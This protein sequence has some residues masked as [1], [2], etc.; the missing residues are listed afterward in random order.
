[1]V[2]YS[3]QRPVILMTSYH[4]FG[5]HIRVYSRDKELMIEINS[6]L[7]NYYGASL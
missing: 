1:M 7:N 5:M 2:V 3:L 6:K 4:S